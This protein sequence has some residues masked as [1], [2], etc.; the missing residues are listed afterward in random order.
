MFFGPAS[1]GLGLKMDATLSSETSVPINQSKSKKPRT[2]SNTA[3]RTW[4]LPEAHSLGD[5][6]VGLWL[7]LGQKLMGNLFL[8]RKW[9]GEEW[10]HKRQTISVRLGTTLGFEFVTCYQFGGSTGLSEQ[11]A[12]YQQW[13]PTVRI[14]KPHYFTFITS[15]AKLSRF[16]NFSFEGSLRVRAVQTAQ[17]S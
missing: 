15:Q 16:Q 4:N 3:A 6:T 17:R 13:V 7:P 1:T 10:W 2:S 14:F 12:R 8:N 11:S 5:S 9:H